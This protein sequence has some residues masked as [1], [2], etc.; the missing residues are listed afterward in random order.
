MR[1]LTIELEG[2]QGVL[3]NLKKEGGKIAKELDQELSAGARDIEKSAKR[4]VPVDTGRLRNSISASRVE[5][6][7]W[8]VV[9]Q[10]NYAA[11]IEFGTG[12]LVDVPAGL[13]AYAIQFKG[14]GIKEVNLPARPFL[15]NS[16]FAYIPKIQK[17]IIEI[18]KRERRL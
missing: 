2:L 17:E 4:L 5:F 12:R 8:E 11:Y 13:E 10:T 9:A 14:R 7:S 1:G 3:N 18:L 6:L 16:V 15:F